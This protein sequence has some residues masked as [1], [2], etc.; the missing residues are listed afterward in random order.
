MM[1]QRYAAIDQGTT[2]TRVVVFGEDGRHHSPASMP[3]KQ[4]TPIR[5]GWN[6]TP[7]DSG[8]YPPLS[9]PVRHGGRHRFRA[10]GR[11]PAGWDADSGL[12]LYNAIVWQ[13]QRTE[14]EI[15][16]LKREG[17]EPL[18]MKTGLPLDTYFSA[19]KMGW[20]MNNAPGPGSWRNARPPAARHH[21]RLLPVP[22]V[23]PASHL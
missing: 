12:P 4:I 5:A 9:Q 2:G 14:P 3:H 6:T 18:V 13:D 22:P 1:N 17:V 16:R 7:G 23:R 8:E 21:G 20:L 11:K 15:Q 19:S 10:S